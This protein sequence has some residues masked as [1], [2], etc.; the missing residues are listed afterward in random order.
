MQAAL[1]PLVQET[2]FPPCIRQLC[3]WHGIRC[4]RGAQRPSLPLTRRCRLNQIPTSRCDTPLPRKG[5]FRILICRPNHRLGNT[6]LLTPLISEL[7]RH[8]K[9]AE[10]DVISEGGIA[11]EV[12]ASFFSVQNVYCLP[13]RGFKHPFPF[14]R[15]LRRVRG[16]QYDL[17]IDPCVGSGFSRALTRLLRGTYKLG[18]SD[19]PNRAGLTH[20]APIDV[21][22]QHMARRPVN[23]LR[24]ALALESTQPDSAPMLDIRLTD[25]E[26]A[27]GRRAI[28]QLLS[29]SR[30]TTSPPVVGVFANAT[31][32]KRY[33]MPWWQ[34]FIDAFKL[35]CPT[36]SILE[37][38]PMH[39]RSMLGAE[40]PAYYSSDIRRMGAVMAGVDLMITA[41][42]G[43]M[44]LAVASRTATI[45]MFC[46]TDESVYAP[47]GQG[48]CPLRTPGLT[49]R[50]AACRV[51]ETY[52]RLLGRE[53]GPPVHARL[54][55]L[56]LRQTLAP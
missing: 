15:L 34:E 9:G 30:Q 35:L 53:A 48:N 10:I 17:V 6:I 5:I 7:E 23:L 16:T 49:A 52:A 44:H 12:F 22:G 8:Y 1:P 55:A 20:A 51:V 38:I 40:W 2:H 42:C 33:P 11:K 19:K 25:A 27:N 31:G 50:Q 14:L 21:A 28:I 26:L 54:D 4:T 32:D 41:D 47:Y 39:G 45:G 3:Q 29:E 46:V 56:S 18:F 13:K 37:L 24:W 43:V 36:A